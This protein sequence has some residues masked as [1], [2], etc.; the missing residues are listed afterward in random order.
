[1]ITHATPSPAFEATLAALYAKRPQVIKPGLARMHAGL[2]ALAAR[3]LPHLPQAP[4]VLVGG[5]NGKGSTI[6]FLYQ[7]LAAAGVRTGLYTSPHLVRFAERMQTSHQVVTDAM[8]EAELAALRRDL[9]A[10]VYDELSFFEAG[11]ILAWRLFARLG[12]EVDLNEVGLG[13]RWDSTNASSPILSVITSLGLDHQEFLGDT[14]AKIAV[15]KAGIL[16]PGHVALWGGDGAADVSACAA[17]EAEAARIGAP[18]RKLGRDFALEPGCVR[19]TVPSGAG[20]PDGAESGEVVLLP[21]PRRAGTWPG[22]LKRNFALACAAAARLFA[23][24][25][26][27]AAR[28][29]AG[30]VSPHVCL[31]RAVAAFDRGEVPAAPSLVGRFDMRTVTG[32]SGPARPVVLDVGHN[33]DG[34]RALVA[35]LRETGLLAGGPLPA[36]VSIL[37]DKD[38]GGILDVLAGSLAPLHLFASGSPRTFTKATLPERYRHLPFHADFE[39][40]WRAVA[41]LPTDRPLVIAGSVHAVG[42]VLS[43]LGIEPLRPPS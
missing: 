3:G 14:T 20:G 21:L 11:T 30:G 15:E 32:P 37:G 2:A 26:T 27:A 24:P 4:V 13:G 36:L 5:T 12:T 29:R 25:A 38:V 41:P 39:A 9:P 6:G 10:A 17:L 43:A 1:L 19:V 18:L 31:E 34:A 7:L 22:F 42:E 40:A 23:L 28:Q 8:I 35:G 33:P 16:R